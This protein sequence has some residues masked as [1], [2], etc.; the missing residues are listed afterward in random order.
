MTDEI[1]RSG[2]EEQEQRI[3][4]LERRNAALSRFVDELN[5]VVIEQDKRLMKLEREFRELMK[6]T[7]PGGS[8][9]V[10]ERPPH[11]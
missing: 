7:G 1:R 10:Q 6:Q 2:G 4:D 3:Y 5:A 8:D 9:S 11:Y